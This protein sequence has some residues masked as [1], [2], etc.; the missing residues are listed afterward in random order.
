[1]TTHSENLGSRKVEP[2]KQNL[3]KWRLYANFLLRE[4][5]RMWYGKKSIFDLQYGH[6]KDSPFWREFVFLFDEMVKLFGKEHG[7][8]EKF[9]DEWLNDAIGR[10][11][12]W[13]GIDLVFSQPSFEAKWRAIYRLGNDL[14]KKLLDDYDVY[15]ILSFVG[16]A[17]FLAC[18]GHKPPYNFFDVRFA[19]LE[20]FEPLPV[21][22]SLEARYYNDKN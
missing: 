17:Y 1:M 20:Y 11:R 22:P 12:M 16:Y 6:G 18:K 21:E 7:Y 15:V 8:H 3:P 4:L 9:M 13:H 14:A 19:P 10:W 5:A 2:K